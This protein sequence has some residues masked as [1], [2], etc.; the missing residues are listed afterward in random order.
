MINK[1]KSAILAATAVAVVSLGATSASAATATGNATARIV[2]ALQITEDTVLNFGTIVPGAA[3]GNVVITAAGAKACDP[4]L[5]CISGTHA[6]GAFTVTGLGGQGVNV[7]VSAPTSLDD[8]GAGVA[9]PLSAL[10]TNT[11]SITLSA[12]A[13]GSA[14]FTVGGTLTVGANQLAGTY[15]GTYTVT[16]NYQ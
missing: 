8:A 4:A 15:T 6:A 3:S 1:F 2:D 13:T 11:G 12:G 10:T 16:A 7:S 9:M 14:S 5:S